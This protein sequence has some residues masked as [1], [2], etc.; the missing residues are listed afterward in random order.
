MK[1]SKSIAFVLMLPVVAQSAHAP[2]RIASRGSLEDQVEIAVHGFHGTV[3]LFA[4]NMDSGRTFGYRPDARVRT[5][6]TIKLPLLAAAFAA[7]AEGRASWEDRVTVLKIN[8]LHQPVV[9]DERR[10]E[11]C[12]GG[13][14][15]NAGRYD[16]AGSTARSP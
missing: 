9:A 15:G 1:V 5:A 12:G 6:S 11:R 16:D 4:K 10:E 2:A 3:N 13:V 7:V 8:Q 14:S